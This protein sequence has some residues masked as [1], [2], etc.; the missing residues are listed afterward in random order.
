M[1]LLLLNFLLLINISSYSQNPSPDKDTSAAQDWNIHFQ[2]T[3]INQ[4]HGSFNSEYSGQNS[5][6]S[7]NENALSVT[8]TLYIGRKMWKNAS[9]YF[10]AEIT[11]GKGLSGARGVAGFTNG[12]CFRIGDPSPVF[13]YSRI[14]LRQYISLGKNEYEKVL[15]DQNQLREW[16]PSNRITI[17]AGKFGLTDIFDNNQYSH[18]PRTQF[19]N[20][21]LMSPG[22]WDYPADTKGYTAGIAVE[23]NKPGFALKFCE[24]LEPSAAN[25]PSLDWDII[26]SHAETIEAGKNFSLFGNESKIKILYFQNFSKAGIYRE[27]INNYKSRADT[28]LNVNTLSE[29]RGRK[30]GFVINFEQN[31]RDIFGLFAKYSWNDGKSSTF[32]YTEIDNSLCM[33]V[34]IFGKKWQRKDDV[35]G[36]AAVLNGISDD[37]RDFLN[38]GGYGFILGDGRLTNYGKEEIIEAY[39]SAKLTEN[40]TLS[41]DYQF[42]QNPGYNKD[43]GPVHVF[44]IRGHLEY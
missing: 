32:A 34:N 9:L 23:Y 11:G 30:Y 5:L 43:R 16:V 20:W 36:L 39:Y 25:G 10:N 21:S 28:S 22:A 3:A 1:K 41:A 31:V 37:H 19:M 15:D 6:S 14:F 44:A 24:S 13:N 7:G 2:F 8:S 26:H 12:E 4:S 33:G 42:I 17:T 27:V 40:L 35:I 29:Y 38:I 18:D